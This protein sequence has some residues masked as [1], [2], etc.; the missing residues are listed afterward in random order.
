[1]TAP[2]RSLLLWIDG[3]YYSAQRILAAFPRLQA[4]MSMSVKSC[5]SSAIPPRLYVSTYVAVVIE[6]ALAVLYEHVYAWSCEQQGHAL[7]RAS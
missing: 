1:M 7:Q 6:E 5:I 4:T 3:K 2:L